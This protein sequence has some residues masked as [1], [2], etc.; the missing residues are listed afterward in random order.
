MVE[1]NNCNLFEVEPFKVVLCILFENETITSEN[2]SDS[3]ENESDSSYV[4]E[5]RRLA[6]LRKKKI[7][8][9]KFKSRLRIN[10]IF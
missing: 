2:E 9:P 3:S 5:E 8:S 10:I 7:R 6:K 1:R 4:K